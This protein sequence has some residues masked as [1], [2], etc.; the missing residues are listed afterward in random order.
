MGG[1]SEQKE[2]LFLAAGLVMAAGSPSGDVH[3]GI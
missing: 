3:W 1:G 2:P